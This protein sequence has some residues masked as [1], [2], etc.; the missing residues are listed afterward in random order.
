MNKIQNSSSN[1][2]NEMIKACHSGDLERVKELF[3]QKVPLDIVSK[4]SQF[5]LMHYAAIGG[6]TK[7]ALWLLK[8]NAP[9][10]SIDTNMGRTPLH[11]A[12]EVG[13][14]PIIGALLAKGAKL[15]CVDLK[16]CI[17]LHLACVAHKDKSPE[18]R[19]RLALRLYAAGA[20][21]KI[22]SISGYKPADYLDE[23]TLQSYEVDGSPT[24][25][26]QDAWVKI[27]ECLPK[28]ELYKNVMLT[29]K[30]LYNLSI[31]TLKNNFYKP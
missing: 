28:E 15:N 12:C 25:L 22:K 14:K 10:D 17:P 30:A 4:G 29:C 21:P 27:L 8:H 6:H 1:L 26:L 13:K 2:P 24:P 7:V 11:F 20:D 23:T 9:F 5:T 19:A 18:F 3:L 31:L 16:G